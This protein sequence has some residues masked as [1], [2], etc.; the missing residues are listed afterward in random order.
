[1]SQSSLAVTAI[2]TAAL[3]SLAMPA[4][5]AAA[6][7]AS[8]FLSGIH[9]TMLLDSTIPANGDANPYALAVAP[10]TVGAIRKGDVLVD[11]FNNRKNLQGT[12]TTIMKYDPKA[13]T[14]SLFARVPET[15]SSC[16]GG[17]GL[18]TAMAILKSGWVIVGSMPS[19]DGTTATRGRG[20]LI[21]LDADGK[22]ATT[23]SRPDIDG[24][25]GNMAV[26]DHGSRA[27]LFLSNIGFGMK[28][29]GQ[30][31]LHRAT[32]LRLELTIGDGGPPAVADA[33]VIGDGFGAKADASVFAY[34]PT[35]LALGDDGTLYV[36]DAA[37]NRIV[38]IGNAATRTDSAGTGTVVT[39]GGLLKRPLAMTSAPGGNLLVTNGLNGQVVEVDPASGTQR[40]AFWADRDEAQTPPGSGDL[41]GIVA[42]PDGTGFYYV[43]DDTNLLREARP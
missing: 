22:V 2:C 16:P 17:V 5:S 21:V 34:G 40:G 8:S 1:M 23:I 13:R 43:E 24:P 25:W 7:D 19:R 36:S 15:L 38:A 33:T 39:A 30:E 32:V 12:G 4:P 27:T 31:M 35:G 11:N 9:R 3:L 20:C 41:F 26:I 37:E 28:A 29:P 14:M 18:T 42:N 6:G 10:A